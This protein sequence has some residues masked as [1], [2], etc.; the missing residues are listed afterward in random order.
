MQNVCWYCVHGIC[1]SSIIHIC[2]CAHLCTLTTIKANKVFAYELF[3]FICFSTIKMQLLME[4]A[5]PQTYLLLLLFLCTASQS[6][7]RWII[8]KAI[9]VNGV[10]EHRMKIERK[11]KKTP[12]VNRFSH[13]IVF[14]KNV[15]RMSANLIT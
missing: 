3:D 10:H 6:K 1:T 13:Y 9:N 2:A 7:S 15:M 4:L 5:A 8:Y 12:Q 11:K 14:N